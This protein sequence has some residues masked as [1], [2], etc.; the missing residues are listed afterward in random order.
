MFPTGT[1]YTRLEN[2]TYTVNAPLVSGTMTVSRSGDT[3]TLQFDFKDDQG[4]TVTGTYE[5]PLNAQRA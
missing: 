2:G 1:T 5:G 3:Y 4:Y